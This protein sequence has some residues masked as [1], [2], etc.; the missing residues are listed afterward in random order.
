[1]HIKYYSLSK[2]LHLLPP[3]PTE[4]DEGIV[5]SDCPCSH[6]STGCLSVNTCF[7]WRHVS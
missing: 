4:G 2:L 7:A 5:F 3:L 1:L 6:L